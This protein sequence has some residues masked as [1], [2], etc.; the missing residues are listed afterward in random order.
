[1]E[2][3]LRGGEVIK[4]GRWELIPQTM[5]EDVRIAVSTSFSPPHV[6]VFIR[7][8]DDGSFRLYDNESRE[9]QHGTYKTMWPFEIAESRG[10]DMICV[11]L[12]DAS[13]LSGMLGEAIRT[14]KTQRARRAR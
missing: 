5:Y 4:R 11:A 6:V 14:L 10:P 9:R 13:P 7:N 1:M 3:I 8:E 12:A 2:P